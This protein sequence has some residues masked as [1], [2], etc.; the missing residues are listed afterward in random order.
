MGQHIGMADLDRRRE[1]REGYEQQPREAGVYALRNK[2]DGR[3]LISS[4]PD[5]RSVRNRYDFAQSTGS[6]GALDGR[7]AREARTVG[8]AAF[9][10]EILDRL[11]VDPETPTDDLAKDLAELE[12]LWKAKLADQPQ[13]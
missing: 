3:L 9:D 8:V 5:L 12:A 7:L 6:V 2:L 11:S 1:L 13:Y 10:L 4:S